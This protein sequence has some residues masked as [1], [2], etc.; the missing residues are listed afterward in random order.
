MPQEFHG[1]KQE[2]PVILTHIGQVSAHAFASCHIH[3]LNGTM[4]IIALKFLRVREK[5]RPL[6]NRPHL[7]S[8]TNASRQSLRPPPQT[9]TISCS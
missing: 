7:C 3:G 9:G 5:P 2:Y 6:D 8:L 1:I 4:M